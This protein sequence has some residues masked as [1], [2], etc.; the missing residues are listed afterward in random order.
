M[1][2][3][4]LAKQMSRILKVSL[5]SVE[6][7]TPI[8]NMGFDSLMSIELKN[9]IETDLGVSV[10]MARLIQGPTLLELTDW[11]MQLLATT[12]SVEA[13]RRCASTDQRI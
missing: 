10:A 12:Q 1:V 9:Q 4:Y 11:V 7:E 2:S 6:Y 3:G 8:S 13:N 5:A